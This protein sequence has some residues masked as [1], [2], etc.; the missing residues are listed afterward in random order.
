MQR[1]S[2]LQLKSVSIN[3]VVQFLLRLATSI[4]TLIATI[5]I[6]YYAGYETLGSFTKIVSFVSIFYL[7]VDFGLNSVFLK[8]HFDNTERYF[9]N[10]ILLRLLFSFTLIPIVA[11]L[12]YLLPENKIAGTGFLDFEKYGIVIFS[13][14][15]ITTGLNISMQ[16]FLQKRL[17]YY[18]SLPPTLL[19]SAVLLFFIIVASLRHD[20]NLLLFSYIASGV[21]LAL[22]L[23]IVIKKKYKLKITKTSN[24]P[25][26]SKTLFLASMP[27]GMMLLFNLLYAKADT[28]ILSIFRPTFDVGVYG[29]SYKFFEVLLAIPA[30]MSNSVYPLLLK[31]GKKQ[32]AYFPFLKRYSYLFFLL[33]LLITVVTFFGAPLITVFKSEFI[34][35]VVPLQILSLSLPFFFLTSIL[36]WHF[37]IK[38]K[39]RFLVPLYGGSLLLNVILN[40]VFVP[41]YSYIASAITTGSSEALVFLIMLWYVIKS[42][43]D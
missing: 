5:L 33:S 38:N 1:F 10:L 43:K 7:I 24:F 32:S 42:K 2:G 29:I 23:L 30:F 12:A 4:P 41:H 40:I 6:A 13:L 9:G 39:L 28:F 35:S 11:I 17:S 27:L 20:L 37:L 21:V 19:S 16:A 26:F 31:N 15:I 8:K 25:Q 22:S 18:V 3:T 14:T 34:K 36:Q